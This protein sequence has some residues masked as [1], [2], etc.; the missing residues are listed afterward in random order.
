MVH[1]DELAA[2][3]LRAYEMGRFFAAARV[4]IVIVPVSV[5][6]LLES[7]GREA[8]ACLA[9]VLLGSAIWLRWRDRE[10]MRSVTTGLLAGALPLLAGLALS[11]FGLRCGVAGSETYCTAFSLLIGAMAGLVVAVREARW[12]RRF[13]SL[14]TAVAIASLA[15]GLGCIRLGVWGLG[16]MVLGVALG[17]T[18]GAAFLKR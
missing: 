6:C 9:I 17:S 16:S 12:R 5:L 7:R 1:P 4:A 11:Q 14:L 3:G 13:T 18:V 8:C 2:R 15:V 10:G